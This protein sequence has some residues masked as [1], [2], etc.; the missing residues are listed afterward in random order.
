MSAHTSSFVANNLSV[1]FATI[2]LRARSHVRT[3]PITYTIKHST[4]LS[5][6]EMDELYE[7]IFE[8][9]P[10]MKNIISMRERFSAVKNF[11]TAACISHRAMSSNEGN[12][13]EC[14]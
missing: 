14:T 2:T 9:S 6:E 5:Q 3:L 13:F 12:Y 8:K 4:Y 7:V 1:E 10:G 11:V